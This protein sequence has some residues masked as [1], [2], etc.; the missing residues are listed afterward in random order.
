[1]VAAVATLAIG[2]EWTLSAD[3]FGQIS[4]AVLTAMV[5]GIAFGALFLSSAPAIVLSFVLPLGWAA[6]GSI[7][8][9]NDAAH[10]LDTTRTTA[11]LTE[12]ALSG[13]EWAQFGT[14]MAAVAGPAAGDRPVPDRA[15]RDPRRLG[16][17]PR[18]CRPGHSSHSET[19][20][21]LGTCGHGSGHQLPGQA[22]RD[23]VAWAQRRA[24]PRSRHRA[25]GPDV[26][27]LGFFIVGPS[28]ALFAFGFATTAH[29]GSA[30]SCLIGLLIT[31][32][33]TRVAYK[34]L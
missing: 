34:H 23:Q 21:P 16:S 9:L 19:R 3:I 33:V 24:P 11:P 26:P 2:G 27:A 31:W 5:T 22:L 17:G 28:L 30:V 25:L 15:R 32:A 29:I 7:R 20:E 6:L 1:M 13:E 10:W 8:F 14:S 4:P 12:R 18:S